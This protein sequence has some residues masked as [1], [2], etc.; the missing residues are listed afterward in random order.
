MN[1][2]RSKSKKWLQPQG[3]AHP[4]ID[5][6]REVFANDGTST[7]LTPNLR[8]LRLA[9]TA[10]DLLLSM[11]V[12]VNSVVSRALDITEAYCDKPANVTITYDLLYISQI[13]SFEDEPF[14]LVRPVPPRAVNNMTVQAVQKLIYEIRTG[15]LSLDKAEERMDKILN[16]PANYP[17]WLPRVANIAIA[18]TVVLMYTTD[19]RMIALTALGAIFVDAIITVL[20][21]RLTVP[22]FRQAAAS[23]VVTLLAAGVTW[24]AGKNIAFFDGLDPTLIVVGGI[25]LLISGLAIVGAVQDA[26]EEYYLTATARLSRVVLL[27][28]GIV[29]GILFGTYVA[30][31]LGV[32]IAV[33]PN[34]LEL[35]ALH[36]QILGG[37]LAAAAQALATQTRL[38]AIIWAG[39]IG[40]SSLALMYASTSLGISIIAAS[41]VAALFVGLVASLFSRLWRTPSSGIIASGI[42]PL[43]PGVTLYTGLMQL[44]SY[45]PGHEFFMHG[46]SSLFSTIS[47]ALAIAIGASLG[48][49]MGRPV[50]RHI[51]RKRNLGPFSDF[52][53]EQLRTDRK[54][55]KLMSLIPRK[56]I[57]RD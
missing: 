22:F 24:L 16:H 5:E 52:M 19:W 21:R 38:G 48:S 30:Q 33:S 41:G 14:T 50:H 23:T 6:L 4:N 47:A 43:V 37:G 3:L 54:A 36:F 55:A 8:G 26:L 17:S 56:L 44:V 13:R 31:K 29:A 32:A 25:F 27:T 15:K 35:T 39:I 40:G 7:A 51:A 12:A 46:V 49:L 20:S 34:P 10:S 42:L 57:K 1:R 28:L 45:P 2:S 9:M 18:P 11:G 53:R